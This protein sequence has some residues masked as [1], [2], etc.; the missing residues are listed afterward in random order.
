MKASATMGPVKNILIPE[1]RFNNVL[2]E[3]NALLTNLFADPI[4]DAVHFKL[5]LLLR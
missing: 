5:I 4:Y 3:P 1:I 2:Y